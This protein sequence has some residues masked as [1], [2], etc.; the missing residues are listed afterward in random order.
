MG[1]NGDI[2]FVITW[3][4]GA[5]PAWKKQKDE[6]S[7]LETGSAEVTGEPADFD[8]RDERYRDYGLLAYWFRA[9]EKF[10]P[11]VRK[12]HFV[13][14]GHL[15]KWLNT[16][17]SKLNIV[18]HEDFIPREFLPTFNCNAIEM[19]LHRIKDLSEHFVYFN[20]DTFLTRPVKET[21][22]FIDGKPCDMLAF[23]PVVANP[24][25]PIMSH[26]FLNNTLVL[27]KYFSK[28]E[29]V[30]M[31]P[32]KYFKIG[33]PPMYFFYNILELAFPKF[34]GFFTVHG[35]VPFCKN[36]FEEVWEKEKEQLNETSSHRFRN[37]D[38]LTDYLLRDWQKLSGNFVAVNLL[39]DF[40]YFELSNDNAKLYS[41]LKK[42]KKKII[43]IND[44][45]EKIDFEH[46]KRELLEV[47]EEI[48]PEKSSFEKTASEEN[49]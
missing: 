24:E 40:E 14:W 18:K 32:G 7:R 36:V 12:V 27:S 47:F 42:H 34:T 20:D 4:D 28:L 30:K 31:Q 33:Y 43:C 11:W 48:L 21:D 13:T 5:D 8:G 15:P 46:T 25:N 45:N 41:A 23:Q 26:L 3:V 29:N 17:C 39:K 35:P 37:K 1:Q 44:A 22:F 38:D 16:D 19:N 2:D 6:Y 10:A 49:Q 9:V